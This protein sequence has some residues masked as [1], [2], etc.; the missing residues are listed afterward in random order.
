MEHQPGPSPLPGGNTF[1]VRRLHSLLG[2]IPVGVFVCMHLA[3]NASILLPGEPGAEFQ[4]AV[5]RIHDLG[6]LL[7]PVEII[8]IF[9]PLFFHALL[10]VKIWLTS[11][12]NVQ[13]YRY[14]SNVRYTLQR[15]TGV[16]AFVF[17][18]Y[19]LWQMHWLG[20]PL[21]GGAF[22]V[23]GEGGASA[24]ATAAEAI[25][26]AW[27]IAPVYAVGVAATVFHLANGVWTSLITWGITIRPKTQRASGYVCAAFGVTLLVM[28]L[29]AVRGFKTF[30]VAGSIARAHAAETTTA[31][32]VP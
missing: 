3:I 26:A 27:W 25:Q 17:I 28:G 8:G 5:E 13:S 20:K 15:V 11:T 29:G 1:L 18:L 6:P 12:P 9:I 24:A 10:G 21:G 32:H 23:H 16:I 2:L 7:T 22:D 4:K 19:H 31:A 14:G 30:A